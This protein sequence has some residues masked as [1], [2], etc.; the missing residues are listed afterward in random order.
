MLSLSNPNSFQR[1]LI[2]KYSKINVMKF[3][4]TNKPSE[5]KMYFYV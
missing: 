3:R 4:L 2:E 1:L 5:M